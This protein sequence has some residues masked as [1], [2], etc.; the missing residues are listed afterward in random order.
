MTIAITDE[1]RALGATAS[2]LLLKRDARGAARALLE[3]PAEELPELWSDVVGLGWLGL[4]LPEAYGGSGFGLE[5]LV[6]VVEELGRAVAPGPFVPTVIA[7]AFLAA[8]GDDALRS[9]LLPGMADGSR[10]AGV[11]LESALTISG[12]KASGS[13]G[14]VVGGGLADVIVVA[15]GDDV[16]VVEP[17]DGVTIQVPPN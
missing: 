1:H 5:E 3:A 14:P 7:S 11:A 8:A 2:E 12:G 6:I 4:H 17:G 9:A 10:T 13:A 15:S 16:V